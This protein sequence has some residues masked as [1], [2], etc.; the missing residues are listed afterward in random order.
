MKRFLW[1]LAM[2][3]L[4]VLGVGVY[5]TIGV[6]LIVLVTTVSMWW[7]FLIPLIVLVDFSIV[8]FLLWWSTDIWEWY[9]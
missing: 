9:R 4:V 1:D 2:T 6:M 7:L 5:A 3:S 8:K